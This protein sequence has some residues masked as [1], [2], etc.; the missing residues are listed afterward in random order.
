MLTYFKYFILILVLPCAFSYSWYG[1]TH[2]ALTE[3]AVSKNNSAINNYFANHLDLSDGMNTKLMLD[4]MVLLGEDRLPEGQLE[5]RLKEIKSPAPL[6]TTILDFFKLGGAIEDVPNPRAKHHF[7]DPY[8]NDGMENKTEH[9]EWANLFSGGTWVWYWGEESFDLRGASNLKRALDQE[10]RIWQAD[11]LNYFTWPSTRTYFYKGLT[12]I[13]K[14]VR[15]HYLALSLLSLGHVLHLLEDMGVPAHTRNDFIYSHFRG[16]YLGGDGNLFEK[17]VERRVR[18]SGIPKS[19]IS[20]QPKAFNKL[21]KYWDS[22]AN[23]T[24]Y[25]GDNQSPPDTWGL[26]E[27]TCYQFLSDSTIFK[28]NSGETKYYFPHPAYEHTDAHIAIPK[29]YKYRYVKGYGIDHLAKKMYIEKYSSYAGYYPP[30]IPSYEIDYTV[31]NDNAIYEDYANVTVP[32]TIAYTTGLANYFFRGKIEVYQTSCYGNPIELTVKNLS[33]NSD[34]EQALKGGEWELYWDDQDGNRAPVGGTIIYYEPDGTLWNSSSILEYDQ[35]T[36]IE[37]W[38]VAPPEGK[39]VAQYVLV[40]KGAINDFNDPNTTDPDDNQAIAV[41]SCTVDTSANCCTITNWET[42]EDYTLPDP[43][44]ITIKISDLTNCECG[45]VNVCTYVGPPAQYSDLNYHPAGFAELLNGEHTLTR[46]GCFHWYKEY[47]FHDSAPFSITRY[48]TQG[49]SGSS[50]FYNSGHIQI[51]VSYEHVTV[52]GQAGIGWKVEI[53]MDC[54]HPGRIFLA[55]G[56]GNQAPTKT[57][58]GCG[59]LT[60]TLGSCDEAYGYY[61]IHPCGSSGTVQLK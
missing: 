30:Y 40:Y 43:N 52:N 39:S 27:A 46:T 21:T 47:E 12:E 3:Q 25:L 55:S 54:G 31:S 17:W 44:Q 41:A 51:W 26:S 34:V 49:C 1:E 16:P 23:L 7:H 45:I 10:D 53:E 48:G 6:E 2:M 32:R 57:L 24:N 4:Q 18:K 29:G 13:E 50:Q 56:L 60:N 11:Y 28:A 38:S 14:N 9:L 42:N 5:K 61:W 22:D 8:R 15:N 19:W 20:S 36:K 37:F 33:M 58:D 35:T 59:K